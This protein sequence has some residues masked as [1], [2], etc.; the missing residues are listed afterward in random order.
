MLLKQCVSVKLKPQ[1]LL[2]V[3]KRWKSNAANKLKKK[4]VPPSKLSG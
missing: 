2:P 3:N 4:S 1:R